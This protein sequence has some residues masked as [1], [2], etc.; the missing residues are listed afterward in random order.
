MHH[1]YVNTRPCRSSRSD[2]GQMPAENNSFS[3]LSY[4]S[5]HSDAGQMPAENIHVSTLSCRSSRSDAGQMP[6]ENV[7]CQYS[8]LSVFSLRCWT[9][10]GRE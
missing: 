4:L 10:A 1:A 6:A 2:A 5:S 9:D 3:T 7:S 8:A